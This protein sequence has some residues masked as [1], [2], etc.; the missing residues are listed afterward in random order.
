[1]SLYV[2][3]YGSL[4][5][6]SENKELNLK[7]KRRVCPVMINGLKRAFNVASSSSGKYK[8]LGVKNTKDA[9][10]KCNGILIQIDREKELA[11]LL[12]REANYIPKEVDLAR[13]RF[14]Y[15]KTLTFQ[16]GDKV[17]C[18]YPQ[19]KFTLTQQASKQVNLR[20]NYL[21]ICLTGAAKF[22]KDFLTDFIA[23]TPELAKH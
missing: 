15:N 11:A 18:F 6:M 16:P 14:P 12:K 22:G 9:D 8:V 7:K 4:I 1:M 3:G 5:N 21:T 19:A 17:V 20:P 23:T 10:K 13:I 2:F